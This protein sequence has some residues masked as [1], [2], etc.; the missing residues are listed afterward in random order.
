[1]TQ[2]IT[3]AHRL[4]RL[5]VLAIGVTTAI[6]LTACGT[7]SDT[8]AAGTPTPS[9]SRTPQGVVTKETATK[10]VDNYE[11]INNE[12]NKT[13]DEKLL[14]TVEAGQVHEGSKADYTLFT[15][16]SAKDRKA[17]GAPFHYKK[18]SYYRPAAGTATWF[19]VKAT[20]SFNSKQ[21]VLMI[22]DKVAGTYK[23]VFALWADEAPIPAIAVDR[24]G[25]ASVANPSQHVGTLA[26]NKLSTAYE[27]L[28][29]T[30]GKKEGKQLTPTK[31]S[32][33][34]LS[35]Y[36]N[37]GKGAEARWSTKNFFAAK[38]AYP[39]V[40]GLELAD[41]GVLAA[42][43]TAHTQ[44]SMLKPAYMGSY[45]MGPNKEEA[46]YNPAKRTVI[47]DTFQGQGLAE[48][49]PKGKPKVTV[50]DYKMVDS[51]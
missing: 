43:P 24:Y 30:G 25:L 44:E 12:A 3:P 9:V 28:F 38:P 8:G 50:M 47:T 1:M 51:R 21:D 16:W 18:R 5:T 22:F 39:K 33:G 26:P 41:G 20:A 40:Y 34:S 37:R 10:V 7:G 46:V 45:Q 19:A 27:D 4:R 2:S 32:K 42:F 13:R 29:E 23:M 35:L 6:T 14:A 49:S 15:T 11:K 31:T 48:L 36:D 17:Y